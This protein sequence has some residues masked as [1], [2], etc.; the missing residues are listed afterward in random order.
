METLN[1]FKNAR[2]FLIVL[3]L[4]IAIDG[5]IIGIFLSDFYERELRDIAR[6]KDGMIEP[7]WLG[8][9]VVY[10]LLALGLTF[11]VVLKDENHSEAGIFLKGALF[12]L[13]VYGLY[14]ISNYSLLNNWKMNVLIVD[15]VWGATLC[16]VV[17]VAVHMINK[18]FR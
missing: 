4:L 2:T 1:F 9:G 7:I 14:N 13:V 16:G 15:I 3:V 8:I 11:Y 6:M 5:M 12:G 10:I 18:L 17:A